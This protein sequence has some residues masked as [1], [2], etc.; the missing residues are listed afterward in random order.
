MNI[1]I[2]ILCHNRFNKADSIIVRLLKKHYDVTIDRENP[3]YVFIQS[4]RFHDTGNYQSDPIRIY[5][6]VEANV[7][8]FNLF[9]Y[10]IL[11]YDDIRY[12]DRCY[13]GDFGW[14]H[15]EF[16]ANY[17]QAETRR[18]KELLTKKKFCNF[19][20]SHSCKER[21]QFFHLLNNYKRI[22][23]FGK[24]LNN[25]GDL[26]PENQRY[27]SGWF[28]S[29]IELKRPYRF[30]IAFENV[31]YP[32]YTTEKILTSFLAGTIPIY[33]GNPRISQEFNSKAFINCHEYESFDAVCERVIEIDNDTTMIQQMVKAPSMTVEQHEKLQY[34]LAKHEPDLESFLCRIIDQPIAKAHRRTLNRFSNKIYAFR[35][36]P[37]YK[38][39][40][41]GKRGKMIFLIR[42]ILIRIFTSKKS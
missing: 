39:G 16:L 5:W 32:G 13:F 25:M 4:H 40:R 29:S 1:R 35:N 26:P 34:A 17:D 12:D 21:D 6:Q 9:D 41:M 31:Y 10:A 37:W 8:D 2:D 38:F 42:R 22:D 14:W 28:P 7:P 33:W 27:A 20:Y 18:R 15:H 3:D 11:R 24:H 36:D 23:S 30:S 19:I